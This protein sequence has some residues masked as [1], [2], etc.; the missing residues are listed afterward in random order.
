M[1]GFLV[2]FIEIY[3]VSSQITSSW[4]IGTYVPNVCVCG[5]SNQCSYAGAES[6]YDGAGII[7]ARILTNGDNPNSTLGT[8]S[9]ICQPV[10]TGI[11]LQ[12]ISQT[13]CDENYMS[14]CCPTDGYTCGIRYPPV[15]RSPQP[16]PGSGQAYYGS[17]PYQAIILSQYNVYIG[18]GVLIDQFHVLTVAHKIYNLNQAIKIRLGDW[19]AAD[20]Y[21]PLPTLDINANFY[22]HPNFTVSNLKNDIAIIRLEKPVILGQYPHIGSI[23][24]PNTTLNGMR[25]WVSGFGKN[26]TDA[27]GRYQNIQKEVD[28]PLVDY[29]TCQ[30]ALRKTALG[31]TFSLDK[32][33]F[34]CAGGENSKDACTGDGGSPLSCYVSG[35]F[36]LAGLVSWGVSCGSEVPSVYVNV[37]S[38]IPWIQNMTASLNLIFSTTSS[39]IKTTARSTIQAAKKTTKVTTAHSTVHAAAKPTKKDKSAKETTKTIKKAVTTTKKST[40]TT[41]RKP[42]TKTTLT[43][44][45]NI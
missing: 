40:K 20:V 25:C 8:N 33:S 15:P 45:E 42:K 12:T 37:Q 4:P 28:V 21:E 14:L 32:N 31:N 24:L 7:Q 10:S 35:R 19:D 43:T 6:S 29:N 18:S 41:T 22:I 5:S 11:N 17:Y 44:A 27:T 13:S 39:T 3:F 30:K 9:T 16:K 2:L 23:C 34:I 26:A 38:F 1:L 36:Y